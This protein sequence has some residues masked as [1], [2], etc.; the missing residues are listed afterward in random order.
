VK[1]KKNKK[2]YQNHVSVSVSVSVKLLNLQSSVVLW[3]A[4][5][6]KTEWIKK[7]LENDLVEHALKDIMDE[8]PHKKSV[9]I[10][11]RL[12]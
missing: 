8:F 11:S 6:S 1:G 5:A 2:F 7:G 12:N 10:K 9:P 3:I 4:E